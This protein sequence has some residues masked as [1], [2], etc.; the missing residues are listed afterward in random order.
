MFYSLLCHS[1]PQSIL[2]TNDN[3]MKTSNKRTIFTLK[4]EVKMDHWKQMM[5]KPQSAV[6]HISMATN[7]EVKVNCLILTKHKQ[8]VVAC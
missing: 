7:H 2:P 5:I 3:T 8:I 6:V 1:I 4:T